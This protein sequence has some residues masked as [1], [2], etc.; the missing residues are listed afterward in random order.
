LWTTD[1]DTNTGLQVVRLTN[2]PSDSPV[3]PHLWKDHA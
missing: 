3:I 1:S 2:E